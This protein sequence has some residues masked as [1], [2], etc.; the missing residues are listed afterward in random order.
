LGALPN[1]AVG[2][3]SVYSKKAGGE[4]KNKTRGRGEAGLDKTSH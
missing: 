1:P 2:M 3:S 4:R